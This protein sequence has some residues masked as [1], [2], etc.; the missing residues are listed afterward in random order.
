MLRFSAVFN[1]TW[2]VVYTNEAQIQHVSI[3]HT[4]QFMGLVMAMLPVMQ[5]LHGTA[6]CLGF[7]V[8]IVTCAK[9]MILLFGDV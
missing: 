5:C 4:L 9:V 1:P 7:L 3:R 8:L 6:Y 2:A